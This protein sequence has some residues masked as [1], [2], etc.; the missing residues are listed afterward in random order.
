MSGE[1]KEKLTENGWQK[2]SVLRKRSRGKAV[3]QRF[4]ALG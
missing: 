2:R 4:M 1:K 3:G